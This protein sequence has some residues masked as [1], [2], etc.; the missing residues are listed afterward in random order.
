MK[1]FRWL[2]KMWRGR[3]APAMDPESLANVVDGFPIINL[4]LNG[5]IPKVPLHQQANNHQVRRVHIPRHQELHWCFLG[6][7]AWLDTLAEMKL[8][9]YPLGAAM[10]LKRG[11]VSDVMW[12]LQVLQL[13][14]VPE[15][16]TLK[17]V[18]RIKKHLSRQIVMLMHASSLKSCEVTRVAAPCIVW[19][20][21]LLSE[22]LTPM[23]SR[24]PGSCLPWKNLK[25]G[26]GSKHTKFGKFCSGC[27]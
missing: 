5:S 12:R 7:C 14:F 24:D 1:V 20:L 19:W 11:V 17:L 26:G 25:V 8:S 9:T 23:G 3:C 18:E 10:M 2:L 22:K 27:F 15:L 6:L 4:N 21:T 16:Y 13:L